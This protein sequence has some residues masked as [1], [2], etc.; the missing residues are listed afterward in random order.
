MKIL[1]IINSLGTGGA[2]KLLLDT[3][4]KYN[5]LG[6]SMDVLVL[7]G[8][9]YPFLGELKK[10]NDVKIYDFGNGTVYNPLHA[11]RIIKFL[12][13]YDLVHVHL[14]PALY[15]VGLAKFISFSRTP[16]LFTEHN[17]SNRRRGNPI[18][19]LLDKWM[20]SRYQKIITISSEV[21]AGIKNHL[22]FKSHRFEYIQN[23]APVN[24][25]K[26]TIPAF[27]N[28]FDLGEQDQILIQVSSFTPQKDQQT[29]IRSLVHLD[30]TV[31]LLLVGDGP[32]LNESKTLVNSLKL[33]DRVQFLGIRMDVPAL[34]RM[35]DTVVLSTHYEGLSLSSIEALASGKPFV[36]SD[37]PG[38]TSMLEGAGV[39]FP[40]GDDTTLA[41]EPKKLL[42]SKRHYDDVVTRCLTIA[43]EF[44]IEKMIEK[45]MSLFS[46][47]ITK[48][49][50]KSSK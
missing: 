30:E 7:N 28:E 46:E 1:Q 2:E 37:A 40:I 21:D 33:Q 15:W 39:L 44:S 20:Y 41:I 11:L 38:V 19:K 8:T 14:F 48:P 29:L 24:E 23:G 16:L 36:A 34:L 49:I 17:T 27:R 10:H 3:V 22:G 9:S 31:K 12:R 6:V 32:L 43:Q 50:H 35:A 18:F 5:A 26:A 47:V 45:H 25:I 42:Q 13:K 4:P